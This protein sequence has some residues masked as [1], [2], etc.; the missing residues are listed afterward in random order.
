MAAIKFKHSA[1]T[2]T[3]LANDNNPLGHRIFNVM[4][5]GIKPGETYNSKKQTKQSTLRIPSKLID[6]AVTFHMVV[7]SL[8][9]LIEEPEY[10][11][12]WY[13]PQAFVWCS[14]L[15]AP[16]C[17]TIDQVFIQWKKVVAGRKSAIYHPIVSGDIVI[18][19][20][21]KITGRFT[22]YSTPLSYE[23]RSNQIKIG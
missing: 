15:Y 22:P 23:P 8:H 9:T 12:Y 6:G 17:S 7:V 3:E 4:P 21:N 20:R 10:E 11:E 19:T 16:S 14:N 2:W 18:K 5:K 1:G 13:I